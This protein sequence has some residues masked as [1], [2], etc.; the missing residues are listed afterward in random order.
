MKNEEINLSVQIGKLILKNPVMPA[1]GTFGYGKEFSEFLDI[2]QL[3]AIVVKSITLN[4]RLGS[5]ENRFIEIGG[6]SFISNIGLQNVGV[7][8]F[9]KEKLP[10]LRQFNTPIIVSIAG[11]SMDEYLRVAEKLN[12]Q[13]GISAL[14]LNLTCPNTE[15]GGMIFA[16]DS[17]ITFNIIKKMKN[18][19]DLPIIPKLLPTKI[20]IKTL[21]KICVEAGADGIRPSAG[22]VGMSIDIITKKSK[23][24]KNLT[25]ALGGPSLKPIALRMVWEVTQTVDIPVIGGGGI[26]CVNDALEFFIVGATAIEVGSYNFINPRVTIEIINGIKKYLIDNGIKRIIDIIGTIESS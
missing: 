23:L 11:D 24:R 18:I 25:G 9:I 7:E 3:G 26:T 17:K 12:M 13:E 4:P 14:Q 20:D 16:A 21:A 5:F 2:N 19:T 1:S 6:C 15:K 22:R 10:F 8:R